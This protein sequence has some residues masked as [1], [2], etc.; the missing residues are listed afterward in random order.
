M[1]NFQGS[2]NQPYFYGTQTSGPTGE[3]SYRGDQLF[4]HE[5][6]SRHQATSV[7]PPSKR[8]EILTP[9]YN[10]YNSDPNRY[11][12]LLHILQNYEIEH[13][14][15][16]DVVR[17]MNFFSTYGD[18]EGFILNK[19]DTMLDASSPVENMIKIIF[20]PGD[21]IDLDARLVGGKRKTRKSRTKKH[22]KKSKTKSK[23]KST[24]SRK[25][26]KPKRGTKLRKRKK[27]RSRK[28]KYARGKT[29]KEYLDAE[30][31]RKASEFREAAQKNW[32]KRVSTVGVEQFKARKRFENEIKK[33]LIKS[34]ANADNYNRMSE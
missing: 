4:S 14:P 8:K 27:T 1:P 22:S 10:S 33:N 11:K 7:A 5:Y 19:L 12:S 16:E 29:M 26:R 15:V 32:E 30:R 9:F 18:E 28:L 23:S 17:A 3:S 34:S 2:S 31:I 24:K 25:L 13:V 6:P 20:N 21:A